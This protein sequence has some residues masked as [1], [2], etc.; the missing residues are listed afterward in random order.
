MSKKMDGFAIVTGAFRGLGAAMIRQLAKE[1]YDVVIDYI[2][3]QFDSNAV[4]KAQ[5]L[6]DEVKK[7]YGVGAIIV[8]AD[9]TDYAQCQKMVDEGVKAFGDKIAVLIN[10]AGIANGTLFAECKKEDFEKM[11]AVNLVGSMYCTHLVLPYMMKA[12]QGCIINQSSVGGVMGVATQADYSASKAG[13]IGFTKALAKELGGFNIRV[14][15]IAP[16]MINTIM[17]A[18]QRPEDVEMLKSVTPLGKIGEPSDISNCMSY[19]LNA[20]FLTG[21]TISPNGGLTI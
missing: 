9:V 10:N 1:G 6:A 2:D 4:E 20:D 3:D 13:L 12:K 8:K 7:E 5:A 19:I 18:S 21:Q 14:N 15:A 16:G 11:I 17:I